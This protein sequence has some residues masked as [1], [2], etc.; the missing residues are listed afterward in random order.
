MGLG[1]TLIPNSSVGPEESSPG[2]VNAS[3]TQAVSD[4]MGTSS[5]MLGRRVRST[6]RHRRITFQVGRA[7]SLE[8]V[9]ES[10]KK[11][12][13]QSGSS[14]L[15]TFARTGMWPWISGNGGLLV[16]S[17]QRKDWERVRPTIALMSK[18]RRTSIHTQ[19]N[20]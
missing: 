10:F 15:I 20:E 3:R 9:L 19:A 13:G 18:N 12:T 14:P 6:A 7:R 17:Y 11:A 1:D 5:T 8:M 4:A 16:W 2:L